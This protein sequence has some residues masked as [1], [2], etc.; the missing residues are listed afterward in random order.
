MQ[1]TDKLCV[2]LDM[3]IIFLGQIQFVIHRM[4]LYLQHQ[5]PVFQHFQ[6]S[7]DCMD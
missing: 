4:L 5:P 1:D 6:S 7:F 2:L 3:D